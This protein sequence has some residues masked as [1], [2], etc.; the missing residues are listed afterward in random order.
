MF[1]SVVTPTYN[2]RA[3]I[4]KA[5]ECFKAQ[6]WPQ[7]CMEWIILDDGTDKV[8]DL[9]EGITNVRYVALP[10][11]VKLSIGAKRNR[12][13]ELATGDIIVCMDDD[14]QYPASR[15]AHAVT[16]LVNNPSVKIVASSVL[17][18]YFQDRKETWLSGPFGPH[19]GT[20][21]TMAYWRSYTKD[22]QC[23]ETVH[24]AEESSFT[25]NWEEP[26][27][28]LNPMDTVLM[29]CHD[30]NT[31]DK[32]YLFKNPASVMRRLI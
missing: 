22:H 28:Q 32:R 2:R 30:S 29:I 11:G 17:P 27:V 19:H 16:T 5:I 21:N 3:F 18:M 8:G 14:D 26:M 13:H 20:F 7:E 1:V 25:N 31:F 24:H 9:F 15:V 6:S 4:P 23:D 12:L 10:E